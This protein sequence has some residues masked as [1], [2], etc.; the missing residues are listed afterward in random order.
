MNY[1]I[2][3]DKLILAFQKDV[4]NV[5]QLYIYIRVSGARGNICIYVYMPI[6]INTTL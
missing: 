1:Q 6:Y 4:Y 2:T 3:N 5:N